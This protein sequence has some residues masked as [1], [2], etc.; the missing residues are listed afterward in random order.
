MSALVSEL[1]PQTAL[2]LVY[3]VVYELVCASVLKAITMPCVFRSQ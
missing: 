2:G 1:P 3:G